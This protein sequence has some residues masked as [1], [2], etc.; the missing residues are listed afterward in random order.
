MIER[1]KSPR[2]SVKMPVYFPEHDMWGITRDIS[3]DGCFVEAPEAISE[4]FLEDIL[5]ELPV[6]GAVALK[7][8]IHHSGKA[9]EGVGMQFVQVRFDPEQS[10]YYDLYSQFVRMMPE[11]EKIRARYL[12]LV[13]KGLLKLQIMPDRPDRGLSASGSRQ[14]EEGAETE[15]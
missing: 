15:K 6:V 9:K 1:R 2:Y 13:T 11:L 10:D 8:Y 4:G 5:L 7:G 3:L 14:V 12:E